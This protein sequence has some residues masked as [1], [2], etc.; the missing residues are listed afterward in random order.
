MKVGYLTYGLNPLGGWG[1]YG[2]D[3]IS[4]MQRSGID[5]VILKI[6]KDSKHP[7]ISALHGG[8]RIFTSAIKSAYYLG[9]CDIIHALDLFPYGVIAYGANFFL[10]KKLVITTQ[11]TYSV[12]PLH[13]WKTKFLSKS[14]FNSADSIISISNFTKQKLSSQINFHDIEVINHGIDLKRFSIKHIDSKDEFILSVGSLKYRKGYHV[15]IPAFALAKKSFPNL[16]Y[17]IIYGRYDDSYLR[18]LKGLV[19][20]YCVEKDVEFLS[21][22]SDGEM[23]GLYQRAKIF[24]LTSCNY[25]YNFEGFGLV[26]LEAAAAGLPA[27]GTLGNGIEDAIRDGYNGILV[28]QNDIEKTAQSIVDMLSDRDK[29]IKMSENSYIWAEEHDLDKVV[30][31]YIKVYERILS[32]NL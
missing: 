23:T 1:R 11:G 12:E 25:G 7:G 10:K 6:D 13:S 20:Q 19:A 31:R 4:G 21:G 3:L 9:D 29:W 26:L 18:Q 17:K 16:K 5:V 30:K 14:A 24:V 22:I 15:S 32:Q 27:I 28:P 2:S 8:A